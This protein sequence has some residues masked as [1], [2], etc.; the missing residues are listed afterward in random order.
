MKKTGLIALIA[1]G[2]VLLGGGSVYAA[3]QIARGNAIGEE[4]ANT[5]A[6]VDAGVLPEE[7]GMIRT[8]FDFDYGRFVYEVDFYANGTKYEYV[9]DSKSGEVL[10]KE[11]EPMPG[12]AQG[13]GSTANNAQT[14]TISME[15]AKQAAVLQ[16]GAD[17]ADVTF[18]TTKLENED[19]VAVYEVEFYIPGQ[20]KY[21]Y[22]VDALT[23]KVIEENIEAWEQEDYTEYR[24]PQDGAA[25]KPTSGSSTSGSTST[26]AKKEIGVDQAK[27][28]ALS[29]AGVSADK[30]VFSKAYQ[31][32]EDGV[33][34]YEIEF[35]VPGVGEYE[36]E[37]NAL[38]GEVRSSDVE[39]YKQQ[40]PASANTTQVQ[41]PTQP[42]QQNVAPPAQQTKPAS[43]QYQ[44]AW[45]DDDD[46]DWDDR[47][48]DWDDWDDDG[49]DR[50]D[51]D[52]DDDDDWD[53]D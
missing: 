36:Y 5:F 26:P 28:I 16:A 50:Y 47:Y 38:T 3:G 29:G 30:A 24:V 40:E 45:D 8:E 42:S 27:N 17:A 43:T 51:D 1:G 49:D 13:K 25:Q 15:E 32:W 41:Q 35:I 31:D 44:P 46:D 7:A 34:V 23:G 6:F 2:A 33:L 22:H 10:N 9:I 37:I 20:K 4:Q 12:S 18:H 19:G 39:H 11:V 21:E 52:D 48:D 53:D 14:S